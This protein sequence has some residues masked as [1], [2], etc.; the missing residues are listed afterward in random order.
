MFR[1]PL[2]IWGATID[3]SKILRKR[4]KIIGIKEVEGLA[5]IKVCDFSDL[6]GI[7]LD[8]SLLVEVQGVEIPLAVAERHTSLGKVSQRNIYSLEKSVLEDNK[9]YVKCTLTEKIKRLGYLGW[10]GPRVRA[11]NYQGSVE[12]VGYSDKYVFNMEIGQKKG[13]NFLVK[14]G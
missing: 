14:V 1:V 6:T 11:Y 8:I 12:V 3:L 7:K 5:S 2:Y 9:F 10:L 4:D 13:E